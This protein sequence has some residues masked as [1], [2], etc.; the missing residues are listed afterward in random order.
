MIGVD[1]A[2]TAVC[3]AVSLLCMLLRRHLLRD[4]E[5]LRAGHQ[6]ADALLQDDA[7]ARWDEAFREVTGRNVP[8]VVAKWPMTCAR[9]GAMGWAGMPR[10]QGCRECAHCG[11]LFTVVGCAYGVE[12]C[13]SSHGMSV[14]HDHDDVVEVRTLGSGKVRRLSRGDG[15]WG[16][17]VR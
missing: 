17:H 10:V 3:W 8:Q 15:P 6:Q 9:C 13:T 7:M 2:V 4:H 14:V 1:W 5:H 12:G 16:Q 11:A